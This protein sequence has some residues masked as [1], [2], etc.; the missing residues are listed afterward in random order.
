MTT[1]EVRAVEA[2]TRK[3]EELVVRMR[4][5]DG[6]TEEARADHV[7]AATGYRVDVGALGFL[8]AGLRAALGTSRGA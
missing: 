6:R 4:G 5:L 2:V 3:D 8:G 1:Q 7:L